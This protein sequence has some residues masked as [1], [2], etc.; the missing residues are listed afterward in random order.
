M[1]AVTYDRPI[2]PPS[3]L[4]LLAEGR[5]LWEAAA[6]V[7]WWPLLRLAPKGDGHAV[8]VLPGLVASDAS[9][10][11]LRR[12]LRYRNYE[13]HGWGQG[14]NLGPRPGVEK[15]M[16][17]LLK[18]LAD[19][20]GQKV[21]LVGWSL[22]GMYAR[23]LAAEYTGEVRDVVTLG[24]PFAGSGR[25]TNAWHIYEAV[26]GRSAEDEAL[27][28]QVRPTP[29]VPT[30]SIYSRS[31]GVVAWQCSL[32]KAGARAENIEVLASHLGMAVHPA[33]LYALA[34][35]LAQP[36]GRWQPFDGARLGPWIYPRPAERA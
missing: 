19:D 20:S 18:K 3:R 7:A 33:V 2:A 28:S 10:G 9:T 4:L 32:E 23:M 25:A 5:A 17:D 13:V 12:Y 8:L 34:D 21:S 6:S 15:G 29:R 16:A 26:S 30:T 35:R 31:D 14:R 1:S 27:W 11:L 24:S 22:G 36:E